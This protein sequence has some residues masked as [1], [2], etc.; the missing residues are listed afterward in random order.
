MQIKKI[1]E[2]LQSLEVKLSADKG[3]FALFAL[4][5]REDSEDKWDL[6]IS[7]PWIEGN[8]KKGLEFIS[9]QIRSY[10]DPQ[11][12]LSISRII[13]VDKENP[14]LEAIQQ[15]IHR[16]ISMEHGIA[17]IVNSNFFGLQIK[18]AFIIT[19]KMITQNMNK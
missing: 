1:A 3:K 7:A 15:A 11:E 12:L 16:A 4:F 18:H 14:A 5:L 6:V 13:F 17:E 8:K 9:K 2:K 10:L 19:S